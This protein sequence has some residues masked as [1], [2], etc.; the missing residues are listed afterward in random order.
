MGAQDCERDRF[1]FERAFRHR[2]YFMLEYRLVQVGDSVLI[3]VLD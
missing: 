2:P 1:V 3:G